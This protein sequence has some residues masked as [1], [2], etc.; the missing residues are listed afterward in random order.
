MRAEV[1]EG[2]GRAAE[3]VGMEPCGKTGTAEVTDTHNR[4]IGK[5]TWFISYAPYN[6]PRY[7]VVVLVESGEFGGTT[8]APVAHD[9]YEAIQKRE[10][11]ETGTLAKAD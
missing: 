6:A 8:C 1:L 7:A 11:G 2:T 5:N 9:I 10:A 4:K 3:V